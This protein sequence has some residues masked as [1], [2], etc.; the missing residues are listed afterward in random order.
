MEMRET[1]E[2]FVRLQWHGN[3]FVTLISDVS[4]LIHK[5]NNHRII[6][7]TLVPSSTT[8]ALVLTL[9]NTAQLGFY[10]CTL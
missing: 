9:I 4:G 7:L 5:Y 2:I 10:H 6:R 3:A 1:R 8:S